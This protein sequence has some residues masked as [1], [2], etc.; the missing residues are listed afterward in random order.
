[1]NIS[2]FSF[3]GWEEAHLK[4]NFSSHELKFVKSPLTLK[5]AKDAKDAEVISVFV[6][7][8]MDKAMLALPMKS[9]PGPER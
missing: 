4:K 1:M 3:E 5:N 7:S 8:K 6:D 2:F 9:N